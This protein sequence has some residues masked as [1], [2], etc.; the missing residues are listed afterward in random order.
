MVLLYHK[1]ERDFGG[2]KY[3]LKAR[4][5]KLEVHAAK[6]ANVTFNGETI[7]MQGKDSKELGVLDQGYIPLKAAKI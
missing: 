7:D 5:Y 2:D 3:V 4:G 1:G 6:G